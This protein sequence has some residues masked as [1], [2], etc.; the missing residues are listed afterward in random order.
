M[1][2]TED[3]SPIFLKEEKNNLRQ[4]AE[5][6]G[7]YLLGKIPDEKSC[8]LYEAAISRLGSSGT[9]ADENIIRFVLSKP[10]FLGLIDS[11]CA[12]FRPGSLLRK[13]LHMMFAV[14][15]SRPAY[16]NLFLPE[17]RKHNSLFY[18]IWV[19]KRAIFKAIIGRFIM[20]FI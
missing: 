5:L 9:P 3:K 15:E 16:A 13:K 8:Q 12:F 19:G 7:K 10:S 11:G 18:A 20:I 1:K 2:L 4:E 17:K 14:L 6:F